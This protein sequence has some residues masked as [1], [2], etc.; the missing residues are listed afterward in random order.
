MQN[1]SCKL[2]I[3]LG[4]GIRDLS[5]E[6]DLQ[7]RIDDGHRVF[8][9]GDIHGHLATFRALIHRLNLRKQ[10]RLI[11]LGDMIDRG[12]DSAGV[13]NLI[14]RDERIVCIKGNHEHM[15]LQSIT[16][17]G[18]V[19]LWQPW[20]MRGGKSCWAS[21]IVQAEGDLY[22]A[23]RNF[24]NDMRWI[25]KLPTQIVLDDFR[26]VHAGYDP[27]MA[28]DSQGDKELL[29]IRKIWYRYTKPVDPQRTV[30][31]GHTTTMKLGAAK[32]G[33]IAKSKFNL[34]NGKPAWMALDTGAY[35]H[36]NPNLSA[37]NL[38]N[39]K[40]TRQTTL[41][42]DRWFETPKPPKRYLGRLRQRARRWKMPENRKES[43]IADSF[44][45][46]Y[47]QL[48]HKNI[49]PAET[50]ARKQINQIGMLIPIADGHELTEQRRPFTWRK[51]AKR[52]KQ[53]QHDNTIPCREWM[54][55]GR[56]IVLGKGTDVNR[57]RP[58][59]PS[60]EAF[61]LYQNKY[62]SVKSMSKTKSK[63]ESSI[64]P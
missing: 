16:N 9:V 52:A 61:C 26:L 50:R 55:R 58:H 30:L 19:E 23:K 2:D 45:L 15:A 18:R 42:K 32:G 41:R 27:R 37:V 7:A 5:L 31:F 22:V 43:R 29:W 44:G 34:K 28:L 60:P 11:C 49:S 54:H 24:L 14:R 13:I 36:V 8:V 51:I 4:P 20:M 39:L 46:K 3:P 53:N 35:N 63:F 1:L 48:K 62:K 25:N 21:Y 59:L 17:D 10:D 64:S 57:E 33:D 6:A 47:L 12:P 40:I 38:A 56:N